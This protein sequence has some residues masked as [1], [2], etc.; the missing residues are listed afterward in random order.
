M[1]SVVSDTAI[2][3]GSVDLKALEAASPHG[4]QQGTVGRRNTNGPGM[5]DVDASEPVQD[6][7]TQGNSVA[8][9][10][11]QLQQQEQRRASDRDGV[12]CGPTAPHS[13]SI[14]SRQ[15]FAYGRSA[16]TVAGASVGDNMPVTVGVGGSIF[17]VH[18]GGLADAANESQQ[19][20]ALTARLGVLARV[21]DQAQ[22]EVVQLMF[23]D[24]YVRFLQ[25]KQGVA[26]GTA[27]PLPSAES[28]VSAAWRNLSVRKKPSAGKP[29]PAQ[30]V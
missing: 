18:T 15:T 20:V 25:H 24:S 22:D 7:P 8:R 19:S 23:H 13:P 21:F 28:G 27:R 3:I 12:Y 30:S 26:A 1:R 29:C 14:H 11:Q 4:A 10:Q 5:L 17:S 2:D 6:L 16:N 9:P